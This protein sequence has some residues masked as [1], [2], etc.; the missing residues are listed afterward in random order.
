MLFIDIISLFINW[1]NKDVCLLAFSLHN[2]LVPSLPPHLACVDRPV[3]LLC[4]CGAAGKLLIHASNFMYYFVTTLRVFT[5]NFIFTFNQH[6]LLIS[7]SDLAEVFQYDS[8]VHVNDYEKC[9]D[10]VCDEV[11]YRHAGE[12]AVAV[13]FDFGGRAVAVRWVDH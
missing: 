6:L 2:P 11:E 10:E 13:W 9:D 8:D 12:A 4:R 3:P 7:M 1:A 5:C